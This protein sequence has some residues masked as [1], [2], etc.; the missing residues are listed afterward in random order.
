M[1]QPFVTKYEY[2]KRATLNISRPL[3]QN[4][5]AVPGGTSMS[6][7]EDMVRDASV[8]ACQLTVSLETSGTESQ[9]NKPSK[10]LLN[11]HLAHKY[12][13]LAVVARLLLLLSV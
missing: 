7:L 5:F 4:P 10:C 8:L 2:F 3:S 13:T 12:R 6:T 9:E 1:H 11:Q